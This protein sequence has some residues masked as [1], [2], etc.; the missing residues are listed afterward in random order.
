MDLETRGPPHRPDPQDP[1]PRVSPARPSR[2]AIPIW[3]QRGLGGSV[4]LALSLGLVVPKVAGAA[5]L[6]IGLT[7]TVW[8][9]LFRQGSGHWPC[10]P[11]KLLAPAIL[12]FVGV[13][14]LGWLINGLHPEGLEALSLVARLL[15][16]IPIVLLLRR[17]PGLARAWWAGLTIGAL[18]AGAY[19]SW[20]YLSGQVGEHGERVIGTTNPLYFGGLALAFAL[21][22]LPRLRDESLSTVVRVITMLAVIAG[23]SASALS[24]SRGAWIALPVLLLVF[25]F[26]LGRNQPWRWR[27]GVPAAL[28]AVALLFM[29]SP[30][31]PMNERAA[32]AARDVT[33]LVQGEHAEGTI[34]RRWM[35]WSIAVS[36]IA[37]EPVTG[38]GPGAYAALIE[39]AVAG[40]ELPAD[41]IDYRHPHNIY[42]SAWLRAGPLGLLS[43]ILLFGALLKHLTS[44]LGQGPRPCRHLAWSGLAGLTTLAVLGLG[45][46]LFER[47]IGVIW[48]GLFAAL[49]LGLRSARRDL[50]LDQA[51][52]RRHRLS[53]IVICKDQSG[54]ID[55]CLGSVSGWAEEI[56]VLDSGSSDD[57][58][59]RCRRYTD[60][61]FETDWPGYGLQ[62]QRALER[63]TGDWVLSL[64][65]D[66]AVSDGLRRE[67]DVVLSARQP[68]FG[69]YCLPWRT[70]AFGATL[71]HGHWSRAP[72]RLFQRSFARFTPVT[73]HERVVLESGAGVGRLEG[74]LEHFVYRDRAHARSKLRRYAS[75]QARER[76]AKGRRVRSPLTPAIRGAF[77]W[78]DN[79]L[80]RLAIL[81]GRAGWV[82]S[83][84][85]ARYTFDKYA[86]LRQLSKDG[87]M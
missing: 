81:D 12:A 36:A 59:E 43:V 79:M 13:W 39:E 11:E 42:L 35:L 58:V 20:S 29:L 78:L 45:E 19:A 52:R 75:L 44:A 27:F 49:P 83:A 60:Q 24:G 63:A 76:H 77:N 55:R 16:I 30:I 25:L 3:L 40:G 9:I 14:L 86:Q 38:I 68:E 62:K 64:D 17:L 51:S 1:A 23:M 57:T 33:A 56:I 65:A 37:G 18:V 50:A 7:A 61:V 66:E 70:H 10:S 2:D 71:A 82:L 84:L 21:M 80:L 32:H 48:F 31:S 73:V 6:L 8:L 22:L 53:V 4:F 87:Q 72:L 34:G 54:E 15:L 46:S 67:I 69:G 26:T 74:P 5:F 41:F 47:N 28:M 85:Y